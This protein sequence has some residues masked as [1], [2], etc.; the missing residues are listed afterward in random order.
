MFCRATIEF[1]SALNYKLTCPDIST[2][3]FRLNRTASP[4]PVQMFIKNAFCNRFRLFVDR[5]KLVLNSALLEQNNLRYLK[6]YFNSGYSKMGPIGFHHLAACPDF[7]SRL[8][9]PESRI[10]Q[11]LAP[12]HIHQRYVSYL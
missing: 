3:D 9:G 1:R 7:P 2:P 6:N 12:V 10:F 4:L 5:F 11:S 8:L